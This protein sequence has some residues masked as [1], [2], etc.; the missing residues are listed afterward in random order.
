MCLKN[1][2]ISQQSCFVLE[3]FHLRRKEPPKTYQISGW[4]SLLLFLCRFFLLPFWLDSSFEEN[5]MKEGTLFQTVISILTAIALLLSTIALTRYE[6]NAEELSLIRRRIQ[7][8]EGQLSKIMTLPDCGLTSGKW[9]YGTIR[10]G[11]GNW[12]YK[13]SSIIF[14]HMWWTKATFSNHM[15]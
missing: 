8:L 1:S 7:E 2:W 5:N 3:Q 4:H 12:K 10:L 13:L 15:L 6:T 9:F 11:N 14:Q